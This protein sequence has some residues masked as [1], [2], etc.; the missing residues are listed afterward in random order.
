MHY[1]WEG[2]CPQIEIAQSRL[3]L[4][5]AAISAA[6]GREVGRR[7][8]ECRRALPWNGTHGICESCYRHRQDERDELEA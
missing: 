2:L 5:N 3:A 8:R 7:C 1:R 4:L 6:L